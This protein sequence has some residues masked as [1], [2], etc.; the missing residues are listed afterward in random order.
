MSPASQ[1]ELLSPSRD[2]SLKSYINIE[3]D[4][5]AYESDRTRNNT[6]QSNG[7]HPI[8]HDEENDAF[9]GL[10]VSFFPP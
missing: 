10:F 5:M 7:S 2:G 4:S 3:L 6:G 9:M 8:T 1:R